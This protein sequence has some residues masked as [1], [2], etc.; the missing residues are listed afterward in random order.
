MNQTENQPREMG[1]VEVWVKLG[2]GV[3][4]LAALSIGIVLVARLW[5]VCWCCKQVKPGTAGR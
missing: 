4:A 2:I 5:A 1:R 3:A